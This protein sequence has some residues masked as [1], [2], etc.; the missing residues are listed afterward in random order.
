MSGN[1]YIKLYRSLMDWEWYQD[2]NALRVF[3]HLLLDANHKQNRWR[4]I[5]VMPGQTITSYE[6]ISSKTGISVQSVRTS[7]KRLKSTGEIT[8]RSTNKYTLISIENWA[9][10]QNDD[11]NLTSKST[12]NLTFNQQATNK[13]LTTNKNDKNDKN[14]QKGIY[15]QMFDEFY[16][17]YPKKLGKQNA[18]KVWEKLKLDDS[19]FQEIMTALAKQ[20]KS[21][22]W[23]KDNGKYIPYPATWLNGRRWEDEIET[24]KVGGDEIPWI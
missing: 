5:E 22:Q 19:L 11:C 14:E 20:K 10:Y 12:S 18:L 15:A 7:I 17:V 16:T 1:G 9:S 6:A 13:Q 8:S 2:G 4:G 23:K 3:L 24:N 21:E